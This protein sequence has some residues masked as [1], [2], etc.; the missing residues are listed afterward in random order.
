MSERILARAIDEW[1]RGDHYE[2]HETLEAVPAK[3]RRARVDLAEAPTS[4]R[5]VDL[6]TLN[7]ELEVFQ[8]ELDRGQLPQTWPR[9]RRI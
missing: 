8:A 6:A 3:L 1:N 7:R 5:G 9:I 2:A 4:W